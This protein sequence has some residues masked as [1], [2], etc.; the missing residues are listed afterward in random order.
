MSDDW[1]DIAASWDN[2]ETRLYAERVFDSWTRQIA[3]LVSNLSNTRLLDFGCGTG[4]LTE[5]LAP[6]CRN[7]VAIDSSESMIEVL[8]TKL[9]DQ[10]IG[11]V[12]PLVTTI[13]P[14]AINTHPE[15]SENF[16]FVVASS[17]CSFLPSYNSTL[18][19]LASVI[20]PGGIYAQW[21]WLSEMPFARIQK[22]FETSGLT[23]LHIGKAFRMSMNNE[24]MPVV[25]GIA[26][27]G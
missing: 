19:V 4:L 7:I 25:L 5:K 16:D 23:S 15:L 18:R 11:N 10:D 17:V 26:R 6:T 21:D 20:R 24:S 22:A 8:K 9:V 13:D 2:A 27:L 14:A 12:T 3:P 1:D